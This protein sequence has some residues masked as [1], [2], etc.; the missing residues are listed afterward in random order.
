MQVIDTPLVVEVL[1]FLLQVSFFTERKPGAYLRSFINGDI[2][3]F[4]VN[5]KFGG[6]NHKLAPVGTTERRIGQNHLPINHNRL[7]E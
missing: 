5:L 4:S 3:S 6:K 2:S 7:I 1:F